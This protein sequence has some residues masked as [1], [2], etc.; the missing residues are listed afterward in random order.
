M[1]GWRRSSYCNTE[2]ACVEV[3]VQHD[4]IAVRDGKVQQ[5]PHLL[6][7]REA[8]RVFMAD[9]KAGGFDRN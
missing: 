8:W 2:S 9:I 5:G 6:L 1:A 7:S 4:A 3:A